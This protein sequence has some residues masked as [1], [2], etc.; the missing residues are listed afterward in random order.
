MSDEQHFR[1]TLVLGSLIAL[2]GL[3]CL[4]GGLA[5]LAWRLIKPGEAVI[6]PPGFDRSVT[7]PTPGIWGTP[8]APP[9]LPDD[10]AQ[11]VI[12]PA[13]EPLV[14]SP[15][16]VPASPVPSFTPAPT[17][18]SPTL[19]FSPTLTPTQ[20]APRKAPSVTPTS[21][22]VPTLTPA[23]PAVPTAA[24]GIPARIRI[25]TIGLDAPVIPVGQHPITLGEQVYSQ[26]DVP[27]FRAAGWQQTSARLGQAGNTVLD[28]HHNMDGE[29]FRYLVALKPGDLLTLESQQGRLY[30]YAVVQMMTLREEDQPVAVRRENA[31]WILPTQD[32]RVTLITCWPYYSNTYRLVVIARPMSDVIPPGPIP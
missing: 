20:I 7:T 14:S 15:T 22:P 31:R 16:P 28:G 27:D 19:V 6:L 26:W 13:S 12:L 11:V 8:L 23:P 1:R 10:P 18:V 9:P 3:V 25:D 30:H 24:P 2:S 29:V 32:E 4:G 5:L 17:A 21:P